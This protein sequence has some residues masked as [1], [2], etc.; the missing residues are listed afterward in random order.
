MLPLL[1]VFEQYIM[2][3]LESMKTPS[4]TLHTLTGSTVL[5]AC[6]AALG[7]LYAGLD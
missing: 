7:S 4:I 6:L 5:H 1:G 3:L 2:L